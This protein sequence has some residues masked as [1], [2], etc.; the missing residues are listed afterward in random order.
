MKKNSI[1]LVGADTGGHVVPVFALAKKLAEHSDLRVLVLGVGT[2]IEK[3]FYLNQKFRYKK[4]YAGKISY[5]SIFQKVY[6]LIKL[7]FGFFQSLWIV[8][9]ENPKVVFLKGNYATVPIA[10]AARLL[11]KKIFVHE[12]DAVIG[13]SN[14]IIGKFATKTFL[15]YPVSDYKNPP[16]NAEYSGPI[17][18]QDFFDQ[19]KSQKTD[20]EK[21]G[22]SEKSKTLL[23]IGGSLGSRSINSAVVGILD[24]LLSTCQ[25][26]HQTGELD[27]NE[28]KDKTNKL[29]K[30]LLK[31]YYLTPFLNEN[32][33]SAIR[34]SDLV[35]SRSGSMVMEL[36]AAK[37]PTI[38]I[39]YPY[40]AADH[41]TKN[42][43]FFQSKNATVVISDKD[44]K[45]ITL[46]TNI[47]KIISSPK[48]LQTLSDNIN[49]S[50]KLDGLNL[51]Y[52]EIIK[53]MR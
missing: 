37:K 39:P 24:K 46:Y 3:K 51:I 40:A 47:I 44:L 33:L 1:I 9:V 31:N 14:K 27:Y 19:T 36:A 21:F 17:L 42:A 13:R 15:T 25:V 38:L 7:I 10:Y 45:P 18:R 52:D 12:S 22:F 48:K 53:S 4:I 11:H 23:I 34:I 29:D 2:D 49:K 20:Y 43:E 50:T 26:I 28:V 6:S 5:G 8:M 35:I 41:Q 32:L 16:E 30:N